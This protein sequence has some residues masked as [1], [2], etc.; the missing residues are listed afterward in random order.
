MLGEDDNDPVRTELGCL[1][2]RSVDGTHKKAKGLP[3]PATK[4]PLLDELSFGRKRRVTRHRH[5]SGEA[6]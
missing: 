2:F 3:E 1:L 4:L 6:N 5:T